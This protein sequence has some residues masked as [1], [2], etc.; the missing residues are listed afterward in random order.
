MKNFVL[1]FSKLMQPLSTLALWLSGTGLV[2]ITAMSAWQ[3]FGRYILNNSPTWTENLSVLFMGWFILL[4]AS[5]GIREGNHLSFE[6]LLHV[7]GPKGN[8]ILNMISDLVVIAFG[9]GMVYYGSQLFKN[10]W[11]TTIPNL[12]VSGGLSFVA[13]IAGGVIIIL[14]SVERIMR[15]LVGLPTARFAEVSE[16]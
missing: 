13:L 9:Y 12:G 11:P 2:A 6:I 4:G 16:E 10:A 5:V 3:V 7:L 15:R 1:Q 14:F 8:F